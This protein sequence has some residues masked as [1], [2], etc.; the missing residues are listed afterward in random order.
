M[1][2][3]VRTTR[4]MLVALANRIP[5]TRLAPLLG[6]SDVG[7]AKVCRRDWIEHARRGHWARREHGRDVER[8][9]LHGPR[10]TWRAI[11]T[12]G[13]GAPDRIRARRDDDLIDLLRRDAD[14]PP[15][16]V[17]KDLR[18]AHPLVRRGASTA[19]RRPHFGDGNLPGI[20][21]DTIIHV[22]RT[23]ESRARRFVDGLL[24]ALEDRRIRT[25][26][27]LRRSR[28]APVIAILGLRF[29][30]RVRFLRVSSRGDELLD[31]RDGGRA[32]D[33]EL[34]LHAQV[35]GARS[36]P[37]WGGSGRRRVERRIDEIVAA[38]V[39][40]AVEERE[41]RRTAGGDGA[42]DRPTPRSP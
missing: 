1:P 25:R 8:F 27:D 42:P 26:P 22:P 40:M 19:A 14:A 4:L 11:V 13:S 7:L 38:L 23:Q 21:A 16:E 28:P 20:A 24:R 3:T 5:M 32:R 2:R 17:P 39:A 29:Q 12:L 15:A 9:R 35:T 36:G 34:V 31:E 33:R 41:R 6:L 37:A 30:L 10:S 18:N